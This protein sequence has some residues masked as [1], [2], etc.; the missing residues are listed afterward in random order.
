MRVQVVLHGGNQV[1]R[2]RHVSDPGI[3]LGRPDDHLAAHPDDTPT[4]LDPV[5]LEVE[6]TASQLCQ[7]TEAHGAPGGEERQPVSVRKVLHD[8]LQLPQARRHDLVGRPH[9]P[10]TSDVRWVERDQR[11]GS[12]RCRRTEDRA[13]QAVGVSPLRLTVRGDPLVPVARRCPAPRRS[14]GSR[15]D[16]R[17]AMRWR[18]PWSRTWM[19]LDTGARPAP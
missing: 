3:G 19:A 6:V 7:L 1:R 11:L 4:N 14:A 2:D 15:H 10:R 13:E 9:V 8:D 5:V 17:P 12:R 16:G 18:R